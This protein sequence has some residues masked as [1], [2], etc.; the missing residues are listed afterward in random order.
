MRIQKTDVLL[1]TGV[2]TAESGREGRVSSDDGR[3]DVTV[4][5]PKEL[6]GAGRGTNPEQLFA[7]TYSACFHASIAIVADAEKV[8]INGSSVTARVSIG[9]NGDGFGI[10]A[11]LTAHLPG[12]EPAVAQKLLDKAH[13]I[14]PYSRMTRNGIEVSLQVG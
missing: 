13:E 4:S 6:G 9:K 8:D 12:V 7:A 1:Y 11:D 14:C 3:L 2:A 10:L 5:Q